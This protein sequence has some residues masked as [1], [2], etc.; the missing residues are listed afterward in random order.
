MMTCD[1]FKRI[2]SAVD[3]PVV[4]LEG[5]R[6]LAGGDADCLHKFGRCL[7]E[8]F[9]AVVFRTGNADGADRAFARGVGEVDE[10]RIEYVLPY[11]GH[12]AKKLCE[13]SYRIALDELPEGAEESVVA[14]SLTASPKYASLMASKDR[15]RK[16]RA[17]A[18]YIL[19]DTMKVTGANNI[20]LRPASAGIFYVNTED[21]ML[22]GTG[23]TIRVCREQGVPVAFQDAWMGWKL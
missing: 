10:S 1:D 23:H 18:N 11:K 12:R 14:A 16:L 13:D 6:K 21:P 20:D 9:P 4:L 19:R 8:T 3:S 5:T 17:K 2:I 22:G 15:I 7:A